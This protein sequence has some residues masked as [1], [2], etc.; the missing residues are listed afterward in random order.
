MRAEED[1]DVQHRTHGGNS[2]ADLRRAQAWAGARRPG[3]KAEAE[4]WRRPAAR[5]ARRLDQSKE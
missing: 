3:P 1:G 5:A 4:R 2:L